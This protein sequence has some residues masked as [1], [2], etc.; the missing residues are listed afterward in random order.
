[1]RYKTTR[2]REQFFLFPVGKLLH[3]FAII[4]QEGISLL[5]IKIRL[6]VP[7]EVLTLH[8]EVSQ[9]NLHHYWERLSHELTAVRKLREASSLHHM[10]LLQLLQVIPRLKGIKRL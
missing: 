9:S 4:V 7:L 3:H 10:Q 1:M 6:H 8:C 2:A 5:H